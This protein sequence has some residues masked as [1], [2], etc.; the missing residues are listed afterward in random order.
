MP[1]PLPLTRTEAYLAYK[2]GVIQQSDLKPSLAIPRNGI[3]AWLAYWTGLTKK[4]PTKNVGKNLFDVHATP[5][6]LNNVTCTVEDDDVVIVH[7]TGSS[8][9]NFAQW[10]LYNLERGKE[11]T[12]SFESVE[13]NVGD[14]TGRV[15]FVGYYKPG[16]ASYTQIGYVDYP[17]TK[18]TF[19]VPDDAE[20]IGVFLYARG[21]NT[22]TYSG[23]MVEA[24]S[25]Q[26]QYEQYTGEPNILQEEEAYIAY[27]SGVVSEYPEKCLRR[28]GAYLRYLISARW[29]RPDHPLNREE[30][31]LSLIKTQVIPSGN[32]SSDIE[33]DGTCKAAFQDVKVYGNTKQN[34]YTGKN[35]FE[36]EIYI[37]SKNGVS[38]EYVDGG[39]IHAYGQPT[40][41]WI[42]C[43]LNYNEGVRDMPVPEGTTLS[44]ASEASGPGYLSL[45]VR[46]RNKNTPT[47][48]T[49]D[50]STGTRTKTTTK[51]N[52][53]MMLYLRV[54]TTK[55]LDA[56]IKVQVTASDTPDYDYEPYVGGI[57]S[58]SEF[59]QQIVE[60]VTGRQSI[61]VTG[62]KNLF[63]KNDYE[64]INCYLNNSQKLVYATGVRS[65]IM[66]CL[67]NTTYTVSKT[68]AGTQ[69]RFCIYTTTNRPEPLMTANVVVGTV[70]GKDEATSYTITT[71]P[72]DEYMLVFLWIS[73][74]DITLE[75]VVN[76][77]QIEIGNQATEYSDYIGSEYEI[78]L[79]KNIADMS[80][81]NYGNI[82]AD[83]TVT[84]STDFCR[85]NMFPIEEGAIYS[86]W[87]DN[88]QETDKA[89]RVA[90][91]DGHKQFMDR[92]SIIPGESGYVT[93]GAPDGAKYIAVAFAIRA[94]MHRVQIEAG[95]KFTGYAEY[96]K[97]IELC[98]L[99]GKSDYI[100]KVDGVWKIHRETYIDVLDGSDDEN[101][102]RS[103]GAFKCNNLSQNG[104]A[105]RPSLGWPDMSAEYY[106]YN[107][108][109][110]THGYM[111]EAYCSGFTSGKA[112]E[113]VAAVNKSGRFGLGAVDTA[114]GNSS[115]YIDSIQDVTI[116][117]FREYLAAA[118]IELAYVVQTPYEETITN[119]ALIAQLEALQNGGAE[120]G[121]T[122]IRLTTSYPNLPALLYVEAPKYE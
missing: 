32:P 57:K 35:L 40:S 29:G 68:N 36:C 27:L 12:L 101:W 96:F 78:N 50:L 73:S 19:T 61:K 14:P 115:I 106:S 9:Y 54:D 46:V 108:P 33:I 111:G 92:P 79:G 102:Y 48:D 30:L 10:N 11:Y 42:P 99:E 24:G 66:R 6:K 83:G 103:S 31:Y 44:L 74:T 65:V 76:T 109:S 4:Y 105:A 38:F 63:N 49:D 2:A 53:Y 37:T 95:D 84:E 62:G 8:Q 51:D 17:E 81:Y 70:T 67:P 56:Y 3:D 100:Y 41:E 110:S 23:V 93:A 120:D 89:I 71:G 25:E 45:T 104:T 52:D 121:M 80:T 20:A 112:W 98:K 91:Y 47:D 69:P 22:Y 64:T 15:L 26:T 87:V 59:Y 21:H 82:L 39:I 28:V 94:G 13:C 16:S 34:S 116:E 118:P 97:P 90:F 58:P 18:Y 86:V 43:S 122:V 88:A 72:N 75:D 7:T 114:G 60:T 117:Q 107:V 5:F 77:L 113:I 85:S 1:Y 119:Q 55:Y